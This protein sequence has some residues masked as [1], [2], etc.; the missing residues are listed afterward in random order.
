MV[1]FTWSKIG[2][3]PRAGICEQIVVIGD[4]GSDGPVQTPGDNSLAVWHKCDAG[5]RG[6]MPAVNPQQSAGRY[7]PQLGRIVAAAG[8]QQLVVGRKYHT[9]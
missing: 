4:P 8:Q 9:A 7:F 5:H 6:S 3:D 1:S 2:P